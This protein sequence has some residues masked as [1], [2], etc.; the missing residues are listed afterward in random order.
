[1]I[2]VRFDFK[3]SSN[4]DDDEVF[5]LVL[6]ASVSTIK[7]LVDKMSNVIK[8]YSTSKLV[9]LNLGNDHKYGQI[10]TNGRM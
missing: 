2:F 5:V 3:M 10:D 9:E 7:S 4:D 8:H 1:M 6:Y